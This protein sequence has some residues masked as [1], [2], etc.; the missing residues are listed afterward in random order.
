LVPNAGENATDRKDSKELES[1]QSVADLTLGEYLQLLADPQSW[2]QLQLSLDRTIFIHRLDTI[3]VIRNDVMH[4]DPDPISDE[5]LATLRR[6][7][8]FLQQFSE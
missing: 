6:F 7:T 8:V 3:R 2:K 1:V 4:F 5:E